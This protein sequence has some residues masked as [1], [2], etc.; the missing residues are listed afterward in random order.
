MRVGSASTTAG[1]TNVRETSFIVG[2][3]TT[4]RVRRGEFG[5]TTMRSP[6]RAGTTGTSAP[7]AM[8]ARTTSGRCAPK[9]SQLPAMPTARPATS[10]TRT[11]GRREDRKGVPVAL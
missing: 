1:S 11:S 7:A 5:G 2:S 8:E 4:S 3:S 9:I 6:T 10:P